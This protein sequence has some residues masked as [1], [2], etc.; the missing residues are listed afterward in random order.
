MRSTSEALEGNRVKLTVAVDEEELR[1]AVEET[2]R[3]LQ[4][5]VNIPGF[6]PGK[7]P[8]RLLEV[9]LGAQAIRAEVIRHALP[10]YYAQAVEAAALDTIAAPEIDITAG[11]DTGPLAF[12]AVVEVRPKV[13]I[14]G[15]E[16][17][18]VTAPSLEPTEEEID[19]RVDRLRE[20]FA[21]LTEVERPAQHGDLVTVDVHGV[22]DGKVTE[23]LSADDFVY[24]IGTGGLAAGADEA[25]QGKKVGEIVE[26]DAPGLQGGPGQLRMLLKQVRE[27][28]LPEAN[29]EW[30]SDASEFDT[31]EELRAD[32][33]RR[34]VSFKKLE[35]RLAV[36]ERALDA[37][38][39]L[40]SDET[41]PTLVHGV[42]ERLSE[43]FVQR[44]A[45]SGMTMDQYL[46]ASGQ[47]ADEVAAELDSQAVS[48]VRVDLALRALADAEGI[49]VD[50]KDLAAEIEML[51]RQANQDARSL[52][53]RLAKTG[54]LE[55]LRSNVRN[56][57]AVEWLTESVDLV[58]EQGNPMDRTLLLEVDDSEAETAGASDAEAADGDAGEDE[59]QS[60]GAPAT[61]SKAV[62]EA[63]A[64]E[65]G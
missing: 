39:A 21:E 46:E 16:G 36:R 24:E 58:D 26:V 27:K 41:P 14:A 1:T 54:G 6:R 47:S 33:A 49:T 57:K 19:A 11:E 20:Q 50:D 32:V 29:D 7:V 31:L 62:S 35:A 55:Q 22:R 60:E 64:D 45:D 25:L 13:S 34:L 4:K 12:D 37:L 23:G 8:R 28:V 44:L 42:A 48:E 30:A 17:L 43:S 65:E 38:A 9:R 61:A 52:A 2:F 63:P 51:A 5:D 3:Q 40:V 59:A 10:D 15:Y 56:D 53:T 18:V